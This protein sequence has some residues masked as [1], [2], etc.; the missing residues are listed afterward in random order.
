MARN[1]TARLVLLAK[2]GLNFAL[3]D[4]LMDDVFSSIW[5][6]ISRPGVKIL[7]VCGLYREH[8]Y[9]NLDSEW[10]LQPVEQN[11]RWSQFLKQVESARISSICHIIG[12]VNLDYKKWDTPDHLHLQMITDSKNIL[13]AGGFFQLVSD[14]TRSWPGQVDS[15]IDHFWTND[16]QKIIEVKNVVRA[17]GDHNVIVAT[18]RMK[19]NDNRKLDSKRRTYKNFDPELFRQKLRAENWEDIYNITDVDLAKDFLESRV[20]ST[21]DELCPYKTIQYRSECKTWL[22][23]ETKEKMNERDNKR[24][25]A[26]ATDD[27]ELWKEYRSLRND[28]N[29]SVNHDKIKHYDDIYN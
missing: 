11:R 5:V 24:E 17:V 4:D 20:V 29:R 26:R 1:R 25:L 13:E 23:V 8:L 10:S 2:N 28:V 21:L 27:S 16:V 12:D 22:T 7:L 3:R 15:L 19:G 6:K 18:I 14:V 9:L